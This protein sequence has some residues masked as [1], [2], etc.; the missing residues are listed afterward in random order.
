M[1]LVIVQLVI[2]VGQVEVE[3]NLFSRD[4]SGRTTIF[5]LPIYYCDWDLFIDLRAPN[6]LERKFDCPV[7]FWPGNDMLL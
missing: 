4:A 6:L 5:L 7:L 3:G 2:L 1:Q